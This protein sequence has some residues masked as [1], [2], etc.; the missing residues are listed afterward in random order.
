M[1][2]ILTYHNKELSTNGDITEIKIWKV[3]VTPDK[4]HGFKYSLVFIHKDKRVVGYD[5]AEQKGDHRHIGYKELKYRFKN[6]KKLFE[7]FNKDI[8]KFNKGVLL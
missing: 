5:N 2:A 3:P 6:I 4:P 1:K 7:D 8:K